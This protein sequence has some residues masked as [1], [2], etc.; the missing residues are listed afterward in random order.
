MALFKK[1]KKDETAELNAVENNSDNTLDLIKEA[2]QEA[3]EEKASLKN[4]MPT[5]DE[6]KQAQEVLNRTKLMQA[7]GGKDLKSLVADFV[8]NRNQEKL[9]AILGCLRAPKTVVCVLA[10]IKTD[11]NDE[12]KIKQGGEVKL[13]GPVQ[14]SPVILTDDKGVNVFPVFTEENA[15]PEELRN[16][17]PK[18]NMPFANCISLMENIDGVDTVVIDP[19]TANIRIEVSVNK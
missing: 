15:I 7:I 11:K 3:R 12:K 9:D 14:I 13:D 18:V 6:I 2:M 19:F 5:A 10:N 8:T 1:K 17:S 16:K 4:E